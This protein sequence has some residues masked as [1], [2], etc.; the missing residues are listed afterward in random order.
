MV[1]KISLDK[2]Q[3]VWYKSIHWAR[4]D[5]TTIVYKQPFL[6]AD[7][8]L[9]SENTRLGSAEKVFKLTTRVGDVYAAYCG[10]CG[11]DNLLNGLVAAHV[12]N[13]P[14][15]VAK[16]VGIIK[17]FAHGG[18]KVGGIVVHV[19]P[20]VVVAPV[21]YLVEPELVLTPFKSEFCTDGSG[22]D[23]ATGALSMGASVWQALHVASQHDIYTDYP[24]SGYDVLTGKYFIH[25]HRKDDF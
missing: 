7:Q 17:N 11:L 24:F 2:S 16:A 15:A 20:G 12:E 5:M 10:D 14:D 22:G 6:V 1:A 3:K 18:T 19:P 8:R 23:I 9:N 4:C 13:D 21:T 25:T